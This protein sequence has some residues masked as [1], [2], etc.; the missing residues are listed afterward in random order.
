MRGREYGTTSLDTPA[1]NADSADAA[2]ESGC[3]MPYVLA[4][5]RSDTGGVSEVCSFGGRRM[6]SRS[7]E[8]PGIRRAL[9]NGQG[10]D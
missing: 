6:L 7:D 5:S 10:G 1:N 8:S 9:I 2:S 3:S 4:G